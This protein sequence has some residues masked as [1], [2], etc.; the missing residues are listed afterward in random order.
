MSKAVVTILG[1]AGY[2]GNT[3][4]LKEHATYI[5]NGVEKRHY[6]I[7][8]LLIEEFGEEYEI[9]PFY[10]E[11][12]KEA[13]KNILEAE[14]KEEWAERLFDNPHAQ[15]IEL[16]NVQNDFDL[17]LQKID[18]TMEAYEEVILDISHGWRHLP[19]LA[20]I[21]AMMQN[22][23][24]PQKIRA[25]LFAKEIEN[26][27][28]YEIVDLR[29]YLDL[30]MLT[31]LLNEFVK[32]YTI[33]NNITFQDKEFEEL[34]RLLREFSIN[35]LSNS[36]FVLIKRGGVIDSILGELDRM[37][38]NETI[39]LFEKK[40]DTI[41][42]YLKHLVDLYRDEEKAEYE[43]H[44]FL[45]KEFLQRD[46]YLNAISFLIESIALK[47]TEIVISLDQEFKE[48]A[49]EKLKQRNGTYAV[50][51]FSKN[52]ILHLD[53]DRFR[54]DKKFSVDREIIE[55]LKRK[56][57]AQPFAKDLSEL[58]HEVNTM[59]NDLIHVNSSKSI[60]DIPARLKKAIDTF[61]RKYMPIR[62][63]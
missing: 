45:A 59:R 49:I 63:Q 53:K 13:N 50:N 60:R 56:L 25:I 38:D 15:N 11:K 28:R 62:I 40:L 31:L 29:S 57:H 1:L 8:P 42:T 14:G 54:T 23:R 6:N 43:K 16:A 12:S 2:D 17:L 9:V 5:Y 4:S 10:T 7:L 47:C 51:N 58:I 52:I 46:Y 19:L 33:L 48:I 18:E 30:A 39:R 27:K 20:F 34:K 26:Q 55:R 36:L 32:N 24:S 35:I 61:E 44:L 22:I 21:D 41:R 3:K 37:Q